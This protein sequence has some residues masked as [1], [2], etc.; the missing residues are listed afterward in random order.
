M[1]FYIYMY[2]N[3]INGKVYIG[4]TKDSLAKRYGRDRY[5]CSTK[6]YNA[7][8]KYGLD[9]FEQYI[10]KIVETQ[11]E[12]D[13]EEIYWIAEMRIQLGKENV[14]NI[15]EGGARGKFSED[16]LKKMSLAQKGRKHSKEQNEQ[17]SITMTGRKQSEETK[18]KKSESMIGYQHSDETKKKISEKAKGRDMSKAVAKSAE[19][20]RGKPMLEETKRK[21]SEAEKGK[22]CSEDT[23]R[24][25][26]E[27]N[28]GEN[29]INS[30]LNNQKVSK[31]RE[32]YALKYSLDTLAEMFLVSKITIYNVVTNRSW[33]KQ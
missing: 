17:H 11:E 9:N 16:A 21:I 13:Q 30:K 2:E 32:L 25:I 5:K 7:L 23:K 20:R 33:K 14:Y 24:K 6:F 19:L 15:R 28:S 31:I 27:A 8:Q 18:K 3:K 12:A 4:Q 22:I 10:F 1:I 26:S 29:N